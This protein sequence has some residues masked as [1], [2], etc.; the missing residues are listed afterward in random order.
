MTRAKVP[1]ST[2]AEVVVAH[3]IERHRADVYQEV[4]VPGG[5]ADIVARVRAELWIVEVKTSLS[6]ALITQAMDRRRLAHRVIIAAPTTR[7]Q[8]DVGAI[9]E[10][11]GLGLWTVK[12]GSDSEWDPSEVRVIVDGRRCNR[13]PV[14]LAAKLRPE[15]QTHAKA[16]SVGAAGR[17]TPYRHT[18]EQLAGVV[19]RDPGITLKAAID[20]IK[21]HYRTASSAR[22]SLAS[23]IQEGRVP[24]VAL[25]KSD[26]GA[27]RLYPSES[28]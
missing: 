11:V 21:H 2:V 19:R 5:V 9:C 27:L 3:L 1:E 22:S 7:H 6:L 25:R 13:R 15:H 26:G 18:C 8:G 4:E 24:G 12:V 10:E 28:P 14:S 17:W 16:G 23:W 20:G